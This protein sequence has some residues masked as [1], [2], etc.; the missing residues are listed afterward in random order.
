MNKLETSFLETY[1]L[2]AWCMSASTIFRA[3]L[4]VV[5]DV[6]DAGGDEDDD[7]GGGELRPCFWN[8]TFLSFFPFLIA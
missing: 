6:F 1:K 7:D 5:I 4:K 2:L 8:M 3:S